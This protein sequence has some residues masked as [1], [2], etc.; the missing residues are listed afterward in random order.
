[1]RLETRMDTGFAGGIRVYPTRIIQVL[2]RGCQ[3]FGL[4]DDARFERAVT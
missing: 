1:M 2:K 3:F 4:C